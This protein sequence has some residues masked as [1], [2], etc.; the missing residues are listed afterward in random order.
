[1][2]VIWKDIPNYN[3]LYQI[4]N[5]AQVKRLKS[6]DK[7]K[8]LRN[9]RILKQHPNSDGYMVVGLHKDGIETKFLVH[10]L[11]AQVFLNNPNN[12]KEVNHKDENP[13]NNCISNLEWCNHRYNTNYGTCQTRRLENFK[14]TILERRKQ[15]C[16]E[17]NY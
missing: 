1:M 11:V 14:K 8:H 16:V 9:E 2:K 3:G 4:S 15:L 5:N 7:R 12:Y 17:K 6:Y 13:K 10:R